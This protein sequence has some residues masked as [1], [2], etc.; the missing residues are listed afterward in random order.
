MQH[1]VV[2]LGQVAH[3]EDDAQV[4]MSTMYFPHRGG[5][6]VHKRPL[7]VLARLE[8]DGATAL[9]V[10]I[11]DKRHDGLAVERVVLPLRLSAYGAIQALLPADVRDLDHA[12]HLDL[13]VGKVFVPSRPSEG[14]HSLLRLTSGG[15]RLSQHRGR[16]ISGA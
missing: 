9:L 8:K 7:R 10:Q 14:E 16:E 3:A 11:V 1:L 4:G 12:S 2:G 6:V 5:H 13:V 15:K